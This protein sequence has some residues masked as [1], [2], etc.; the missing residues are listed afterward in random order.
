MAVAA[1]TANNR[2]LDLGRDADSRRHRPTGCSANSTSRPA[3]RTVGSR[4]S[5]TRC[6][7]RTGCRCTPVASRSPTPATIGSW[8]GNSDDDTGRTIERITGRR[9]RAGRRVPPVRVP[10]GHRARLWTASSATTRPGCSSRCAVEAT[11]I[12]RFVGRLEH[13]QP[14]LAR[15]DAIR[16]GAATTGRH[17]G[18]ASSRA[19]TPTAT[20]ARATRHRH[21]CDDCLDEFRR[22]A[23]SPLPAPLHHLHELR[24]TVHDHHRPALRP[25]RHDDGRLR[26]V[27]PCRR[28]VRG[29]RRPSVSR[30][31]DRV[32]RLWTDIAARHGDRCGRCRRR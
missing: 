32:P 17:P 13:E 11:T 23:R 6:A 29:S 12:D 22:P 5:T 30:P 14:P 7:G 19:P 21:V 8:S 16:R 4:C 26:D 27:H 28:R 25:S 9:G 3:A 18:S 31:T 10:A 15:I 2:V 20:H 1:D 24:P